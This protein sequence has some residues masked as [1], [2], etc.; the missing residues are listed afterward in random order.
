MNRRKIGRIANQINGGDWVDT[1]QKSQN[2]TPKNRIIK[3]KLV[4]ATG[5]EKASQRQWPN[6]HWTSGNIYCH[7]FLFHLKTFLRKQIT[8]QRNKKRRWIEINQISGRWPGIRIGISFGLPGFFQNS[9]NSSIFGFFNEH[10]AHFK[11]F[12]KVFYPLCS[13]GPLNRKL[14]QLL[15]C[16][17]S[18]WP[19]Q[20]LKISS[21]NQ[22][23]P[24]KSIIIIPLQ[25]HL[26]HNEQLIV[27]KRLKIEIIR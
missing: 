1:S 26:P 2:C 19:L 4:T 8:F 24:S 6:S 10:I 7:F 23:P 3:M 25:F 5:E 11:V 9:F 18:P 15:N 17:C 21:K 13:M 20:R 14:L 22:T 12:L 27:I 16:S